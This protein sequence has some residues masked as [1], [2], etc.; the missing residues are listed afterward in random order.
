M[1]GGSHLGDFFSNRQEPG[2]AGL[3]VMSV[4]MN[5]SLVLRDDMERRTES[6]LKPDQHLLVRKGD[7][8]YNMM[9]MWQG[10]FGLATS[11][12]IVS[13]AYVVLAPKPGIDSR[14]AYHWFKSAR[15]IHLFWAYS[16]GL[17]EDRLRLY[18]DAF[19]EIPAV[20]PDLEQQRRIVVAL[21]VWDQAIDQT[22]R[23]IAAKRLRKRAIS[24]E[25]F[26]KLPKRPLL[27]AAD[28]WFSG[29]DKKSSANETSVLLCNYMD[30]FHNARITSKLNFMRATASD[31]EI[32]SNTLR[33]HDVVFTKDSETSEEIA[34]PALIAEDI[35]SLVCG[36]HLAIA[37]PYRGV[38]YGPFLAQAMRHQEIR[39][40][41]CRLA[42]GVVRFGL[43]LDALEQVEIFLP[44]MK[45]QQQIAAVLD[46]E[47]LA[48]EGLTMRID[49]LRSQKCG[50]MQRLLAGSCPFDK[51]FDLLDLAPKPTLTGGTA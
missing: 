23:M 4:T 31:T 28:V 33:K 39:W 14:F 36:Y 29:I 7:I 41:F 44:S 13:P 50:L 19:A 37:R 32:K 27:E 49:C 16:H 34:E 6:A 38:G 48:V 40:Q 22:E 25:L 26:S 46:A 21:D 47:D 20:P 45:L 18:F 43:T 24:Q 15:M 11:E 1:S 35:E 8:A 2:Q 3:P 9:R 10:A 51:S 42:N 30:V 17:T 5:D 12:C